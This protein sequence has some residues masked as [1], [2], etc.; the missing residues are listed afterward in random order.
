LSVDP[1]DLCPP[2]NMLEMKPSET[3]MHFA[4][5]YLYFYPGH[6]DSG[7]PLTKE[8]KTNMEL[9]EYMDER[10]EAARKYALQGKP[11]LSR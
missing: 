3:A 11:A 7:K 1:E 5:G 4:R 6:P 8:F 9:L 2:S 10:K